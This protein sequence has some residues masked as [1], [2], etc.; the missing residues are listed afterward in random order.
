MIERE[1]VIT[2]WELHRARCS[3]YAHLVRK[4]ATEK[5]QANLRKWA[6]DDLIEGKFDVGKINRLMVRLEARL[7]R[8]D[9]EQRAVKAR[10]LKENKGYRLQEK[11]LLHGGG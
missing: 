4:Q 9:S 1:V 8:K 6:V 5:E 10:I 2:E 3:S 11:R 7:L